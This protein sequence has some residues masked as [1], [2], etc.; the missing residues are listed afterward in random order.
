MDS[1]TPYKPD[2]VII[3]VYSVGKVELNRITV[4]IEAFHR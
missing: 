2:T 3:Y 4:L 1:E